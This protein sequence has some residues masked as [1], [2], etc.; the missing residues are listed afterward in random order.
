MYQFNVIWLK[1]F[2]FCLF[3]REIYWK[4][5]SFSKSFGKFISN[6]LNI[7][8]I[9]RSFASLRQRKS[10]VIS[11]LTFQIQS[12]LRNNYNSCKT[13]CKRAEN[14]NIRTLYLT[15]QEFTRLQDEFFRTC[16]FCYPILNIIFKSTC[17]FAGTV[18]QII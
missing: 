11:K 18:I 10:N 13:V 12:I 16:Q 17:F 6:S 5:Q 15:Y 8:L 2:P 7:E 1:V 3:S 4:V 9:S 14:D